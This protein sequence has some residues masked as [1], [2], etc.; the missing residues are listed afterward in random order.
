M[1]LVVNRTMIMKKFAALT[2]APVQAGD[3]TGMAP[4]FGRISDCTR[5]FGLLRGTLYNLLRDGKIQ[6]VLLRVKGQKSG[7]R[8]IDL[9]SCR[10][11]IRRCQAEQEAA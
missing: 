3:T 6:G 11:Y 5:L 8:L 9:Q 7:V 2:T 1:V 10:D 4:E